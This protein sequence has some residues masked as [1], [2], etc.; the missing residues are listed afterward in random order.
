MG[1]AAPTVDAEGHVWVATGNSAFHSSGDTYDD[2]DGV[3]ELSPSLH[4]LDSFAPLDWYADNASD[5]DL[6]STT[7][8]VLSNGL[9]FEVGKSQTAYVLRQSHLG[10]VGGQ[11]QLKA[12]FLSLI[13]I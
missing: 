2:S 4:L 13:H 7:P 10:G 11:I 5:L 12:N 1:G 8:A 3:L 6:G 9:V